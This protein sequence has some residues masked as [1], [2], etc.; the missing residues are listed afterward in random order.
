MG[1]EWVERQKLQGVFVTIMFL[2]VKYG[3]HHSRG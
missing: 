1:Q 2:L 3:P